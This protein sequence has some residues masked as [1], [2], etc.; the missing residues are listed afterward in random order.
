MNRSRSILDRLH[1][2]GH[3]QGSNQKQKE[4]RSQNTTQ[5]VVTLVFNTHKKE[6]FNVYRY[7]PN[8]SGL[9]F[10]DFYFSQ[11]HSISLLLLYYPITVGIQ[12]GLLGPVAVLSL[13][14]D[15]HQAVTATRNKPRT[16]RK[17]LATANR[18]GEQTEERPF[19]FMEY[20]VSN[21]NLKEPIRT[22]QRNSKKQFFTAYIFSLFINEHIL[23]HFFFY[24]FP[25]ELEG[26]QPTLLQPMVWALLIFSA[27]HWLLLLYVSTL[28]APSLEPQA[29]TSPKSWGA[30]ATLTTQEENRIREISK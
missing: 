6:L 10:A 14:P 19:Y 5:L 30:Q 15:L 28:M 26:H 8:L 18:I 11:L 22:H 24:L 20:R 25:E 9:V 3:N 13:L 29:S 7:A 23:K 2:T 4:N 1:N 16:K 12:L 21:L 17:S 27:S